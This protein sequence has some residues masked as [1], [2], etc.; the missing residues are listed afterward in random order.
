[1]TAQPVDE[2]GDPFPGR[3]TASTITILIEGVDPGGIPSFAE[4]LEGS[5][6][7]LVRLV[8]VLVLLTGALVPFFWV[9]LLVWLVWRLRRPRTTDSSSDTALSATGGSEES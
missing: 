5:W 3:P 7:V 1:V 2:E 6:N 9:P 4:G 8:Q